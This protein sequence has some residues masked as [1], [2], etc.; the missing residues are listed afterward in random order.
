MSAAQQDHEGVRVTTVGR[1]P[2][3]FPEPAADD[4][5]DQLEYPRALEEVARRAV[6]PL[7]AARVL[8]R[9]PSADP[10]AVVAELGAV[11]EL[12]T[13]LVGGDPLRPEP[14][15]D[16]TPLLERM[17]VPG[18]VLDG[19]ELATLGRALE[20]MR[21]VRAELGRVS[22]AAPLTAALAVE[23][24]PAGLGR[25]LLRML[26][27]D[28]LVRDG[29]DPG[30]DRA[31]RKV[32][33]ARDRLV[34]TLERTLRGLASHEVPPDAGPTVRGGRY[35]MPILRDAR[36]RVPGIVHAESGSGA[37]LFV[38]PHACTELGNALA[39][40]EAAEGRAVLALLRRLTDDLRPHAAAAAAGQEMCVRLDDRYARARY[41]T[42]VDAA[43]P[44]VT[45]AP[46]PHRLAGARHPLLLAEGVEAVPFD[47]ELSPDELALVVSGPN[48]G[49]KTVLLKA[50]GLSSALA[51]AGVLPPL[52]EGS[53][54]PVYQALH[55]DIGD[56]QSIA[57][58][59]STFSA[60]LGAL[61]RALA[62]AGPATLVLLDELGAGTDPTEGAALA[63][64]VLEALVGAGARVVATTHLSELKRLAAE[65][66]GIVN[67]S[68]QFDGATLAPTYRLTKGIPGR[69]YG[70]VI[71][72][73]LGIPDEVVRRAEGRVP[74]AERSLDAVL[75]DAERR[76]AE[77]RE[78]DIALDALQARLAR[79]QQE[80][81]ARQDAVSAG[82]RD[83][84]AR[85]TA[86][87]REG[88]EQARRFLLEAR[89]RVEEALGVARAAVSEA[90]AKEARRLVEEGI[91]D[92]AAALKR[93]E[94]ELANRGWRVKSGSGE[95]EVDQTRRLR[96][97]RAGHPGTARRPAS[98]GPTPEVQHP[99]SEVDLRG[100]TAEEAREAVDRAIDA[101]VLADLPVVR[102]IHGKGTGVLRAA[103]DEQLRRDRR[104]ASH[105]LAPPREGGSGVTVAELA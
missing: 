75:A 105:R 72:R 91:S 98:G 40:A 95:V 45:P 16:V 21:V 15:S 74:D 10:E 83:V 4:V 31:R 14:V 100:M 28:G 104:V 22:E 39:A 61:H 63:G 6:G 81:A 92:E 80:L 52:G 86:L 57:A 44:R 79:L 58:S 11:A 18:S 17:S 24:P 5:L 1:T 71:A 84:A 38:E 60:H 102:I 67:A 97:S 73:R 27:P 87:E 64:A 76:L 19:S 12:R 62:V 2:S 56:R 23:P 49:G 36:G 82:E 94:A 89:K 25:E 43:L 35:V 50:V 54:L 26:D 103:V 3:A 68:L 9:R 65:T 70:L 90:T 66:P 69:S 53:V 88:R 46:G 78:R 59:L 13:L 37:T 8:E 29:A 99:V 30:V 34:Q 41:A 101:A 85:A 32:R 20:A 48:T 33:D 7:G 93:L 77:V 55:A 51:Q 96:P 42:D 47:L